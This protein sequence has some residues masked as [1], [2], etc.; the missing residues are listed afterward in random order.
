[1]DIH[2]WP[3]LVGSDS[4]PLEVGMCFSNEPMICIPGQ[5]GIRHE[6]HFYMTA[7]GPKWFTEPAH[8]ID[9]RFGLAAHSVFCTKPTYRRRATK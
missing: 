8:R 9:A 3:Y 4:T 2:E 7:T 1:M 6:D 5:F